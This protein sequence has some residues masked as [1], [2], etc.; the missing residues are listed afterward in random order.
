MRRWPTTRKRRAASGSSARITISF[1][2]AITQLA[3]AMSAQRQAVGVP[4][5]EAVRRVRLGVAETSHGLN[6]LRGAGVHRGGWRCWRGERGALR[7]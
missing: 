7:L 4:V 5:T 6:G 1:G 2:L 3:G